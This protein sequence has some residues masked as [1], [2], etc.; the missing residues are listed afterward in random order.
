M[1]A[2]E[3]L[4]REIS[5]ELDRLEL[6]IEQIGEIEEERDAAI[7]ASAASTTE[8]TA[9][10]GAQLI[11]LRGVGAETATILV[12]EAFYRSFTNRKA[13]A[14]SR[15]IARR[16]SAVNSIYELPTFIPE[17]LDPLV[18]LHQRILF[19]NDLENHIINFACSFDRM[20]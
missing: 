2:A 17:F 12:R 16:T 14:S 18:D 8:P 10:M 7:K 1:S 9:A 3:C 13:L 15:A 5:R 6:V 20:S 19:A 4:R 11:R